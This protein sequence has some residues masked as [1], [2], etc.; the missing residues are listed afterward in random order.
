M[1]IELH[2]HGIGLVVSLNHWRGIEGEVREFGIVAMGKL[3][4]VVVSVGL[5]WWLG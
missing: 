2:R 1:V 3:K 4:N 5:A